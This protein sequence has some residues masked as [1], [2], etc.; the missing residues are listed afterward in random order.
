MARQLFVKT[1]PGGWNSVSDLFVKT[2][3]EQW[4]SIKDVWVK[5]SPTSWIKSFSQTDLVPYYTVEPTLE[6][7]AYLPNVFEDGN[8]ITLTRGTWANVSAAFDPVSYSLKIQYSADNVNW[9]DAVTGTGTTLSYTISISDVRSPSYYFRGRVVATNKNGSSTPYLTT[10]ILSNMDFSVTSIVAYTSGGQ[11]FSNWTFNKTNSSSNVSSQTFKIYNNFAYTYNSQYFPAN[12]IVY[13]ASI[14]VG[15]SLATV[16]KTGTNIKPG[17]SVYAYIDAVANDTAG[18]LASDYSTDF[19]APFSGTVTI[20]PSF[21]E[22]G[23]YRRVES[24]S[25]VSAVVDGFPAGTTFT[26]QWYRSRSFSSQDD[27]S[28]G[29]GQSIVLTTSSSV[30]GE[31]IWVDAYPTYLGQTLDTTFSGQHRIIPAP[32]SFTLGGGGSSITIT[33]LTA[34]GGEFYFGTYSGPTSGTILETPIGVDYII[35]DLVTGTYTV[36]LYSRAINGSMFSYVVTESNTATS[37]QKNIVALN[38][39][40]SVSATFSN[41]TFNITFSGGSGPYYQVWYS[42]TSNPGVNNPNSLNVTSYDFNGSSSPIS[43][44]PNFVSEGTTYYFWVRSSNSLTTTTPGDYSAWSSPYGQATPIA[45]SSLSAS[46][47]FNDKIRLTWSGGSSSAYQVYWSSSA[48]YRPPDQNAYF[49]FSAGSSSPYDW[50][51]AAR[52]T[53]YYFFIRSSFANGTIFSNWFPATTPGSVGRAKLYSPNYPTSL[54]GT[55]DSSS[56]ITISW[57]APLTS[58]FYDAASGYDIYYTTSSFS[59]PGNDTLPIT[60]TTSTSKQI[61]GLSSG[62]TYYLYVRSTNE[63]NTGSSASMWTGPS[64]KTTTSNYTVTWDANGGSVSP[65]SSEVTAGSSVTAP[66]PSRSGFTL[67][68]WY[69]SSSGGSFIVNA[70]SSYTPSGNIT[71]YAQWAAAFVAPTCPAPSWGAGFFQRTSSI[72]RWYTDYPTPSGSWSSITGMQFEIRTTAGGGTLLASGQRSF[73]GFGTYPYAGAGGSVWAFRCGTS[74]GDIAYS[75]SNRFARARVV[76]LGTNGTTYY[77]TWT[78]WY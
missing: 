24:G 35:P 47:S 2:A 26:Y 36:T 75:A 10:P 7:N 67:N 19:T 76:M 39:P 5:V 21:A 63:D 27:I 33:S 29:S 44:T 54:N 23:G 71:L 57:T 4:A 20:S 48:S 58:T 46:N 40:T 60:T 56:A 15:T 6:S 52:G 34:N 3:P 14:P 45:I 78:G 65:T 50:T 73:P 68:G 11:I 31:R 70:G 18:T 64:I 13:S 41:G 43:W 32:P 53:N 74:D 55:V 66:T 28:I 8:I 37:Q 69:N 62:T 77:G 12:S 25:T 38:P 16:P 1:S 51:S 22:S 42:T 72:I 9:T 49:D 30:T 61:T 17:E 59:T